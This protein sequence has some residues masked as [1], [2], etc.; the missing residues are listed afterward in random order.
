MDF[1]EL[2]REIERMRTWRSGLSGGSGVDLDETIEAFD[3]TL[4][5]LR[6]A[7]E[8][9]RRVG[10]G[11]ATA[12]ADLAA[13]QTRYRS[14]FD[15]SPI[16]HLVTDPYGAVLEANRAATDLLNIRSRHLTGKPLACF[17]PPESVPEFR[18]EL[19]R[20]RWGDRLDDYLTRLIPRHRPAIHA[21][22][23]ANP[24]QGADGT[25][26][27]LL[28]AVRD[29]TAQVEAEAEVRSF[30]GRLESQVRERTAQLEEQILAQES[31]L[32]AA[33][34]AGDGGFLDLVQGIDAIVWR[35]EAGSG[36]YSFVSR[37][38]E[39]LL[40]HPAARWTSEP[41]FWADI[42]H[43]DDRDWA[44]GQRQRALA[45][46]RDHE[47]EYRLI[48]SDGHPIWFRESVRLGR[49]ESGRPTELRGLLVS[50]GRRKK[51]ERQLYSSRQHLSEELSDLRYVHEL[52]TRL[53]PAAALG[54]L[55][56][57]ILRAVASML[58]AERAALYRRGTAG[59]VLGVGL[60]LSEKDAD[61]L[62]RTSQAWRA[63]IL[64][65]GESSAFGDL[66]RMAGHDADRAL[67]L[68]AGIRA[69]YTV[70]ILGHDGSLLATV[71]AFFADAHEP[72]ERP[73]ELVET[74]MR[75]AAG[76]FENALLRHDLQDADRRKDEAL[77]T[78]AHE[79]RSPLSAVLHASS[80][81]RSSD[82]S[83]L[84]LARSAVERQAR[85]MS[86]LIE[87]LLDTCRLRGGKA[88]LQKG[89]VDLVAAAAAV[90]E[91]ARAMVEA[92]GNRLVV[93]LP[94]G[95]A[96]LMADADRLEQI[97][98]NLLANAAKFTGPGGTVRLAVAVEP[99]ALALRVS[100]D[101][102][103]LDPEFLPRAFDLFAQGGGTVGGLGIGLALV[104]ELAEAH[105]GSVSA[106]SPGPDQG[107][108]FVVRLPKGPPPAGEPTDR[109]LAPPATDREAP[110]P[111]R[112]LL[113]DDHADS[114]RILAA[115][116]RMAGHEVLVANDGPSALEAARE[117]PPEVVLLD[118]GLPGMD[119][120]EVA[121]RLRAEPR[122]DP[123]RIVALTGFGG[124]EDRTRTS[125]AG[126]DAHLV[127]PIDSQALRALL[128]RPAGPT[129]R[130]A[131][132]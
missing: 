92:R 122:P 101:G 104:K 128:E 131:G 59:W 126:F 130:P 47:S 82:P 70:P 30:Q 58:G 111:R 117:H 103:G 11:L 12:Q 97:A 26:T 50:I 51:V 8:E 123:L 35:A 9:L 86:R 89:S 83:E 85:H 27:S 81:L 116:L 98:V 4:E 76:F 96:W 84:A 80:A 67:A 62:A 63:L 2:G 13:E 132:R 37:R 14:L 78:L 15:S 34:A 54:P 120:L 100:D 124:E 41:D 113:V 72:R 24:A 115:L 108:E 33:H 6:V 7:D 32:I 102:I 95:P 77:A 49:D 19:T 60:G 114:A 107:C 18:A 105:G 1:G 61:C 129:P 90:A 36:T 73:A 57:E 48:A 45:D 118:L 43:P 127:K 39:E 44:I 29:I 125:E 22:L 28:W 79:L 75:Q 10:T 94:R 3:V 38:A 40:G 119:G 121:R 110:V 23:S 91:S 64:G 53:S 17:I 93:D 106:S 56:Q 46:G 25:V 65:A 88:S 5:E 66:G 52:F 71:A 42:L 16:G 112:I 31:L 109:G 74:F 21:C 69:V 68:D 87:D 55:S 20:L 99:E